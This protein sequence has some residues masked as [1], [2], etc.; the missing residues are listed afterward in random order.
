MNT[1]GSGKPI[2]KLALRVLRV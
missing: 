2:R 1:S